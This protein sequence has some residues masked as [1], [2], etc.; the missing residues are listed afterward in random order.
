M[1]CASKRVTKCWAVWFLEENVLRV[2]GDTVIQYWEG[3]YFLKPMK[4]YDD[5]QLGIASNEEYRVAN[6]LSTWSLFRKP[7]GIPAPYQLSHPYTLQ[8]PILF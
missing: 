1:E 2:A 3:S 4:G 5:K 7:S 8:L 6:I